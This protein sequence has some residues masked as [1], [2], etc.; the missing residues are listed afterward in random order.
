VIVNTNAPREVHGWWGIY[1]PMRHN[2]DGFDGF[3]CIIR[4]MMVLWA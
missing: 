1:D 4:R 2:G 3:I